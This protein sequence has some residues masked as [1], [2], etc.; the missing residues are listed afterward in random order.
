MLGPHKYNLTIKPNGAD[1][2]STGDLDVNAT[3]PPLT[4]EGAGVSATT[5]NGSTL[6]DRI[7][8][9]LAG[10]TV[11]LKDLT[12]SGG[13]APTGATGSNGSQLPTIVVPYR[14]RPRVPRWRDPQRGSDDARRRGA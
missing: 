11:T 1:D 3:S 13:H 9:A 5:I 14:R 12:I 4:I 10:I 8:H 2:Q 7:L 6:Q